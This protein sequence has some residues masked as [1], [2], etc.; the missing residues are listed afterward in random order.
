MAK[1]KPN[2]LLTNKQRQQQEQQQQQ[3]FAQFKDHDLL[4]L[5]EA[6]A[7]M[8]NKQNKTTN[9]TTKT[10]NH[11]CDLDFRHRKYKNLPTERN[12]NNTKLGKTE[13]ALK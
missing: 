11:V 7:K 4:Q 3:S 9:Q 12:K 2:A 13:T 8:S 1:E 10:T 5:H 6:F